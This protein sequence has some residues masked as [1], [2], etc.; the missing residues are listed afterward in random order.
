MQAPLKSIFYFI[1]SDILFHHDDYLTVGIYYGK[2]AITVKFVIKPGRKE[3][4][5]VFQK[6]IE[7]QKWQQQK[8]ALGDK[9]IFKYYSKYS[10]IKLIKFYHNS[11]IFHR[12]CKER[13]AVQLLY[14]KEIDCIFLF[15]KFENVCS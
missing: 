10:M 1:R 7:L 5:Y 8:S 4:V 9:K 2:A 14:F 3:S 15:A 13:H 6:F 11:R 12:I